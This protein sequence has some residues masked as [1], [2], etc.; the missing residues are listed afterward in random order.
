[1][2]EVRLK[3]GDP[4]DL[5]TIH[6]GYLS[7][8]GATVS[9]VS[10][11]PD[12]ARVRMFRVYKSG[13]ASLPNHSVGPYPQQPPSSPEAWSCTYGQLEQTNDLGQ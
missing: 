13:S 3:I 6:R 12:H 10:S 1:M 9:G 7:D 2:L 4:D 5:G 8:D 11:F